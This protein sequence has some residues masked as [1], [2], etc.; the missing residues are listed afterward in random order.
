MANWPLATN[1]L[2]R[3]SFP[4]NTLIG[5]AAGGEKPRQAIIRAIALDP[6]FLV[7]DKPMASLDPAGRR[8]LKALVERTNERKTI[9]LF[10][11]HQ[12]PDLKRV[13]VEAAFRR[14]GKT[15]LQRCLDAPTVCT[16]CIVGN[17][18]L[19]LMPFASEFSRTDKNGSAR[20][21]REAGCPRVADPR[22]HC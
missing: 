19:K 16:V 22:G 7:P 15:V 14:N 9:T 1:C 21:L 12:L 3:C 5:K 11:T 8:N 20:W 13:A 10:S 2:L 6:A 18:A 17:N 4:L